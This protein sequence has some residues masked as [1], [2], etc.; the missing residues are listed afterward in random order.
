MYYFNYIF[1]GIVAADDE[2]ILWNAM[3]KFMLSFNFNFN[4]IDILKIQKVL[5]MLNT[6]LYLFILIFAFG[7]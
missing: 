1:E 5:S 7:F 6:E 3:F 4:N 2:F